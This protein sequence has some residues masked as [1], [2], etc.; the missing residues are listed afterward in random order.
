MVGGNETW[1][2]AATRE[3]MRK[4]GEGRSRIFTVKMMKTKM[5]WPGKSR[6]SRTLYKNM[7]CHCLSQKNTKKRIP[8]RHGMWLPGL[9]FAG[10]TFAARQV[11]AEGAVRQL[12]KFLF[13]GTFFSN[14]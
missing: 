12:L 1:M 13:F 9:L 5:V 2:T 3:K 8:A 6:L 14:R 10:S 7:R 4:S 11:P